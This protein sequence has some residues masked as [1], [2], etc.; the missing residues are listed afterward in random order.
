MTYFHT[1]LDSY[2]CHFHTQRS[3]YSILYT[4]TK[5]HTPNN[6]KMLSDQPS[7]CVQVRNVVRTHVT[8]TVVYP[9]P[10]VSLILVVFVSYW[11]ELIVN[12]G[13]SCQRQQ[14]RK[15]TVTQ[16]KWRQFCVEDGG[17]LEIVFYAVKVT[18]VG[19]QF[20]TDFDSE[21]MFMF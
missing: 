15:M 18:F 7:K 2:T 6:A 21:S 12:P 19:Y 20:L 9:F 17:L 13:V 16:P 1:F 8:L 5:L 4:Y 3:T 14:R 11:M 10:V